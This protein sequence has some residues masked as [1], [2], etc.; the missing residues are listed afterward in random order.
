MSLGSKL[1][2][3]HRA[4]SQSSRRR[5]YESSMSQKLSDIEREIRAEERRKR[6]KKRRKKRQNRVQPIMEPISSSL[7][8]IQAQRLKQLQ[9]CSNPI[10]ESSDVSELNGH[11]G[12]IGNKALIPTH[13]IG[14]SNI[15]SDSVIT[16]NSISEI[17]LPQTRSKQP[18][19]SIFTAQAALPP[20]AN[21]NEKEDNSN[22]NV[23]NLKGANPSPSGSYRRGRR[24]EVKLEMTETSFYQEDD[25]NIE[26]G[27]N[28]TIHTE[29]NCQES[30]EIR[31]NLK[32]LGPL[33]NEIFEQARAGS[34]NSSQTVGSSR[35]GSASSRGSKGSQSNSKDQ[36]KYATT[37]VHLPPERP[38]NDM[39][40]T[41]RKRP[42]SGDYV[43][44]SKRN[45]QKR[46][47]GPRKSQSQP[48]SRVSSAVGHK[49]QIG[50]NGK[51]DFTEG[52]NWSRFLQGKGHS[53]GPMF[54]PSH[55]PLD[56]TQRQFYQAPVIFD[57]HQGQ[58][59]IMDKSHFEKEHQ[60][61]PG[62]VTS[63]KPDAVVAHVEEEPNATYE[64]RRP[65]TNP[66]RRYQ[67]TVDVL[68]DENDQ[69]EDD[70]GFSSRL[71]QTQNGV[72]ILNVEAEHCRLC[73]AHKTH[74]QNIDVLNIQAEQVEENP[75]QPVN[76]DVLN[77]EAEHR[78]KP[79]KDSSG[80]SSPNKNVGNPKTC[81]NSHEGCN[82][83]VLESGHVNNGVDRHNKH[84]TKDSKFVT[85]DFKKSEHVK[86]DVLSNIH[87]VNA[88]VH[89]A[90]E[91]YS[92]EEKV[93]KLLHEPVRPH[94]GP[95]PDKDDTDSKVEEAVSAFSGVGDRKKNVPNKV[96]TLA[97]ITTDNPSQNQAPLKSVP[98]ANTNILN[99]E[100]IRQQHLLKKRK[101]GSQ[102]SLSSGS[103][104]ASA[105][106]GSA[107]SRNSRARQQ[108][109]AKVTIP[110]YDDKKSNDKKTVTVERNLGMFDF[111]DY[112]EFNSEYDDITTD[113]LTDTYTY[114]S[115]DDDLTE[116][117]SLPC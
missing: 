86:G 43:L 2:S 83:L 104:S 69:D 64:L 101:L 72:N 63:E 42:F 12:N 85:N 27:G 73:G 59:K 36:F 15:L 16:G 117:S 11:I 88:E 103:R 38:R 35:L 107:S 84:I 34:R 68:P 92:K 79:N 58:L 50:H 56:K 8:A 71:S 105:N 95:G 53:P 48:S 90:D 10:S 45:M 114:T 9:K 6:R 111:I 20:T 102:G 78:T 21:R 41:E 39:E 31:G 70:S 49:R 97:S 24:R 108:P 87:H 26:I 51:L 4:S 99:L 17:E 5:S 106:T 18:D 3:S 93:T 89:Q 116:V 65:Y 112:E 19:L 22:G 55:Q 44:T 98:T 74:A 54:G 67:T 47:E 37:K 1:S 75:D 81:P 82:L 32:E 109:Q 46:D 115:C 25:D 33:V 29:E 57:K 66:Y 94:T 91:S 23:S 113:D 100:Q 61:S 28:Q 80:I 60:V 77:V 62:N 52:L 13:S 76:L 110:G 7:A 30:G 14:S 96:K 40:R